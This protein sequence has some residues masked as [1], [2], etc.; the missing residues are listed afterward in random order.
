[1]TAISK[2]LADALYDHLV[3]N[4][5][6]SSPTTVYVAL[7]ASGGSTPAHPGKDA[8]T[9]FGNE[10]DFSG[11]QRQEIDFEAPSGSEV[12]EGGNS[13]S[14]VFPELPQGA[15]T[16]EVTGV[17]IWTAE[18]GGTAGGSGTLLFAGPIDSVKEFTAGDAPLVGQDAVALVIGEA[19]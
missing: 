15:S 11:Y 19:L 17:S 13:N 10:L 12:A 1:M 6:F 8:A 7:H 14:I 4:T 5:P 9:V 3:R 2:P 18:K 16:V